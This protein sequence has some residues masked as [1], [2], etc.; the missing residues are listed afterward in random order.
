MGKATGA[1]VGALAIG[2]VAVVLGGAHSVFVPVRLA[3]GQRAPAPET[4]AQ[5]PSTGGGATDQ[6]PTPDAGDGGQV[7]IGDAT[8]S[9]HTP[10]TTDFGTHAD[11]DYPLID[12]ARAK[13]LW[14]EGL[15]VFI[16]ARPLHQYEEGHIQDAYWM[17]ASE[18]SAAMI[19]EIQKWAGGYAG[20]VVIYCV[21][22]D[23]DASE[24][25]AVRLEE[26]LFTN[27]LIMRDGYDDWAGAGFDTEAGP[28]REVSE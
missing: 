13:A 8:G 24:N 1:V 12:L 18:V 9:T 23:C 22:G 5:E 6:A 4:S 15:A 27:L 10:A 11:S 17:P 25:V 16:D 20:P 26:A 21:G 14:D 2:G 28:P 19:F 3:G 7:V